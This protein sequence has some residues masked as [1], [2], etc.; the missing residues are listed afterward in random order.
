MILLMYRRHGR[1]FSTERR[2]VHCR[3]HA[4]R[5][6]HRILDT[7]EWQTRDELANAIFEWIKCSYNPKRRNSSIRMNSRV[8]FETPTPGQTKITDPTP[9]V[10][11]LWE[12]NLT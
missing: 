3:A 2:L 5:T 8:T 11:V 12:R 4:H 9:E 1:L 7:K 10:S 6:R